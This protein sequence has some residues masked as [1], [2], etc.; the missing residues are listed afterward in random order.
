MASLNEP[1]TIGLLFSQTGVTS[2]IERTQR[3]AAML[4]VDEVNRAG[5][6]DGRELLIEDSDPASDA[7][8]FRTEAERL[9]DA[10]VATIF[11]CYM[12]ST[13]KAVLPVVEQRRKLLFYPTLYEGFEFSSCCVYS[14]AAPNQNSRWLADYLTETYGLRYFFVGSNYVFPYESNRIMRDLLHH[15]GAKVVDEVYIPLRPHDDDI[16]RVMER[17]KAGGPMVIFSTV[18]GEGSVKFYQAYDRAGFDRT[19]YPIASLTSGEPELLAVGKDASIGNVT[20]A[21]YFSVLETEAN[22]RFTTAYRERFG[23]DMPISAGTEAAY[24][25][26]HLFA[27]AVRRSGATDR[28][29]LLRVLPTFSFEAPQG[30]VQVE[31]STHHTYLWPRVAVVGESGRFEIVREASA[32]VKPDPYLIEYDDE[33][34]MSASRVAKGGGTV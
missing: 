24:F 31:E 19:K 17:I 21:P 16:D 1:V 30:P 6:I 13:R 4:A 27:E 12:S 32:Q 2:V 8:K 3:Q 18:V 20:A 34:E 9:L 7:V 23:A 14:G 26:V 29:S 25:Q 22:R 28:E 10:G 15:R 33:F 11:G 5:G